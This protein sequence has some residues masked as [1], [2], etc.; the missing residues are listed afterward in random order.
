MREPV[1]SRRRD[2]PALA[3][4]LTARLAATAAP[5]ARIRA[6]IDA[7]LQRAAERLARRAV[8]GM[9]GQVSAAMV[10]ADHRSGEILQVGGADLDR[11]GAERGSSIYELERHARPARRAPS[12]SVTAY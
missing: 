3:P 4:H 9:A 6:T 5:G 11:H 8:A 2:F 7:G 1:P 10:L 12:R